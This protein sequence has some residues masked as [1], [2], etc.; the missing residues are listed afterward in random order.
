MEI[1]IF[2][3][4]GFA[5]CMH[6]AYTYV[7]SHLLKIIANTWIPALILSAFTSCMV[8]LQLPNKQ[9][10]DW[11][12]TNL[13]TTV[14]ILGSLAVCILVANLLFTTSSI[15]MINKHS[16]WKQFHRVCIYF[17]LALVIYI[18][19]AALFIFI[20]KEITLHLIKDTKLY[21]IFTA[22]LI[23]LGIAL[24]CFFMPP[25]TYIFYKY[26]DRRDSHPKNFFNDFKIG[27]HHWGIN[28]AVI[29]LGELIIAIAMTIITIP[30]DILVFAQISSQLGALDGDPLGVPEYFTPL[31]FIT[32]T[33]VIFIYCYFQFWLI[34]AL[35]CAYGSIEAQEKEKSTHKIQ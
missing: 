26:N 10:I 7:S 11:A 8:I 25:F 12:N 17:L 33:A 22:I 21:I 27:L 6:E 16:Y 13:W 29:F 1:K 19:F 28:I 34:T 18:I 23:I 35:Y 2:E 14:A 15:V 31:L 30:A 3:N 32:L 9:L 20:D 4:H 24:F 5:S